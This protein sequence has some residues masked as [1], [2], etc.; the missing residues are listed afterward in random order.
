[1]Y[2]QMKILERMVII[3]RS[4]EVGDVIATDKSEEN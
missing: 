1:M 4:Y 2:R 3:V